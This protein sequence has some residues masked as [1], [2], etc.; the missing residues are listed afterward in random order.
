MFSG[1]ETA[2]FSKDKA[3]DSPA[4][5]TPELSTFQSLLSPSSIHGGNVSQ[6]SLLS[7]VRMLPTE[8]GPP[9]SEANDLHHQQQQQQ[10]QQCHKGSGGDGIIG[11][12]DTSSGHNDAGSGVSRGSSSGGGAHD[13]PAKGRPSAIEGRCA[14]ANFSLGRPQSGGGQ[15]Q[16]AQPMPEDPLAMASLLSYHGASGDE[17]DE[18]SSDEDGGRRH[19]RDPVAPFGNVEE[20]GGADDVDNVQP[21]S[22]LRHRRNCLRGPPIAAVM[23]PDTVSGRGVVGERSSSMKL[24]I[25]QEDPPL[26]PHQRRRRSV[27]KDSITLSS[28]TSNSS[29]DEREGQGLEAAQGRRRAGEGADDA[30]SLLPSTL[31]LPDYIPSSALPCP[32]A[33]CDVKDNVSDT[34]GDSVQSASGSLHSSPPDVTLWGVDGG[35]RRKRIKKVS[36]YILGPL[37]GEGTYGVVRDCIDL[38]TD[39]ADRRFSRCAIKIVSGNYAKL[40][41]PTAKL[42]KASSTSPA[43]TEDGNDNGHGRHS[44][45]TDRGALAGP[46]KRTS[47]MQYRREEDL[48][49]QETFLRE[50][51]NLQRF[52]S[53]NIIRALDTFTRY[54]KEYVV[55]PIAICN[56]RQLVQQLLRT[57]WREA[58]RE[59][60]RAQRRL[61]RSQRHNQ[62]IWAPAAHGDQVQPQPQRSLW[63]PMV[64]SAV[65]DLDVDI[66]T[67]M[68]DA[69]RG[70]GED[71]DGVSA[72]RSRG[73]S[74][75]DDAAAGTW[76]SKA[77]VICHDDRQRR[78]CGSITTTHTIN[79]CTDR[80]Y[81][82]HTSQSPQQPSSGPRPTFAGG[83]HH[84]SGGDESWEDDISDGS[85]VS[86][87]GTTNS[88]AVI[89]ATPR[90]LSAAEPPVECDNLVDRSATSA[91]SNGTEGRPTATAP[92][93]PGASTLHSRPHMSL[94]TCSPTLLKGI[95]YQLISGVAYLHQQHLAHND[96]KPSNVL[97]FE[98]GTVKL[99][100]LGSVSDTY[101][102][103]G[104]PLFASPE[105]C[106]YF[107]GA[108][109]PP[110]SF[111]KSPQHVGRDA[112]QSSDMWCCGLILY[113]LITGKPGP[114]PVQL[115][116]FRMLN[117]KQTHQQLRP[118][119][120]HGDKDD[121]SDTY[122]D[123][124]S[125]P[126][127]VTRYQ[128]YR[129]IAQQ[130]TP[131]NLSDLPDMVPPDVCDDML[132]PDT[133]TLNT[134]EAS[135]GD[136]EREKAMLP[137]PPNSV[138]HLLARLLDLDPLRRLTAEQALR[139]PWLRIAFRSKMS[140]TSSSSS[141]SS[142]GHQQ[143]QQQQRKPP[144]KQAMEEAIQRDV[145]R[146]VMESR[147]VQHMLRRDRQRHL[148]FVADCCNMLNL[149]IP[150]EII[151]AHAEEPYQEADGARV[152]SSS[153]PALPV[154][155]PNS[156]AAAAA[157]VS[158]RS[159]HHGAR[160]TDANAQG[161]RD[162]TGGSEWS[163]TSPNN[164][165]ATVT[166]VVLRDSMRP[167]VM[168]PGCIDTKLFLPPSEEDYYEQKSGKA[169]FDVRVLRRKPL[170]MAQLDEYFHNVVLVQCGYRTGPDP[171]YQVMRL[172]AVPIEDENGGG[173]HYG[174]GS[175]GCRG[176]AQQPAVMILS[177]ANGGLYRRSP[178]V[179]PSSMPP[180]A[181]LAATGPHYYGTDG[182]NRDGRSTE[183]WGAGLHRNPSAHVEDRGVAT[184]AAFSAGAASGRRANVSGACT[185]TGQPLIDTSLSGAA[186]AAAAEASANRAA[187]QSRASAGGTGNGANDV[188]SSSV[189][190][191]GSG[192][193][194]SGGRHRAAGRGRR[195]GQRDASESQSEGETN[196]AMRESSKCLC[197]LV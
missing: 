122:T 2:A 106:K 73:S 85:S 118:F 177:G 67:F 96:I 19:C 128:L 8:E 183:V 182:A 59:W 142:S 79:H 121:A 39:N 195:R 180:A 24:L 6:L 81:W 160:Y 130:T 165:A 78:N 48:K 47:G 131:V 196:V 163:V 30:S 181:A 169:E 178:P 113:Y 36:H 126:P 152:R 114:L 188:V 70:D 100:D 109:T 21:G 28:T 88:I 26:L 76:D 27:P 112:A 151:K 75:D 61:Q 190:C 77:N 57:R 1:E 11:S 192:N 5:P 105:L 120:L 186:A 93:G 89:S 90:G 176:G 197:G 58:V 50:M 101:N 34:G 41:T 159:T 42:S 164:S 38:N 179:G 102:D 44:H 145:A 157:A 65:E 87:T 92:P 189:L 110:A 107:Y 29:G 69:A 37:L 15:P 153:P 174:G 46:L 191:Y 103:Q 111:S 56:L 86:T 16:H 22:P 139:H 146:R 104:S 97:L 150:P 127:V 124:A 60:R 94:P 123:Q 91:G 147:H 80:L 136:S 158:G 156:L 170:L 125:L 23:T 95:F 137:Y 108:T 167:R 55:M 98:D 141:S 143:Q 51:R 71:T 68:T 13:A 4:Q 185:V 132:L 3:G 9:T 133:P 14:D 149:Q 161:L 31:E 66:I 166:G 35:L 84:H 17:Q 135:E 33:A 12:K 194:G 74:D 40:S 148:Q 45:G 83:Y 175:G 155:R 43:K 162:D 184:A 25:A 117:N 99:A 115:R 53:K 172:R 64:P 82:V 173:Y 7:A 134:V 140:A 72:S 32:R 20:G 168:P 18:D 129:E 193:A 10:Q 154:H 63:L 171:N 138:R 119:T 52:H 54:S 144:S 49:R 187:A 116:Y 62:G